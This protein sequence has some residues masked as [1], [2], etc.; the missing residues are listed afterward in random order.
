MVWAQVLV[1][2]AQVQI[3]VEPVAA[4]AQ[5]EQTGYQEDL[6]EYSQSLVVLALYV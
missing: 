5:V 1:E 4:W 6:E 2:L 3:V